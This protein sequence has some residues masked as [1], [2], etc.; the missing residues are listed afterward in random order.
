M[1]RPHL[2]SAWLARLPA[3]FAALII[4][5]ALAFI[6]FV[7]VRRAESPD[8][9]FEAAAR[10][11]PMA[12]LPGPSLIRPACRSSQVYRQRRELCLRSLIPMS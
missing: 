1:H 9:A 10:T 6:P 7:P 11:A 4:V 12:L 3:T 5:I 8:G 2:S